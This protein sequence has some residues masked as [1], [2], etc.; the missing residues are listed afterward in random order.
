MGALYNRLYTFC[1]YV[2]TTARYHV[3]NDG[4]YL[5]HSMLM[6]MVQKIHA[7]KGLKTS[8]PTNQQALSYF[9]TRVLADKI[10]Y[11]MVYNK[12]M[13]RVLGDNHQSCDTTQHTWAFNS[14]LF[15]Y[16][17]LDMSK[18]IVKGTKNIKY[19][20]MV[21]YGD[22]SASWEICTT[23]SFSTRKYSGFASLPSSERKR[24]LIDSKQDWYEIDLKSA[25]FQSL[26][27]QTNDD[28]MYNLIASGD[29]YRGKKGTEEYKINKQKALSVIFASISRDKRVQHACDY[30]SLATYTNIPIT[31]AYG[32]CAYI[33]D[34]LARNVGTYGN[35]GNKRTW[36]DILQ[37]EQYIDNAMMTFAQQDKQGI[38]WITGAL[39]V[40]DAL[41]V[42]GADN[43]RRVADYL[44]SNRLIYTLDNIVA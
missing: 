11:R 24:L 17:D 26:A 38:H 12:G 16:I 7:I 15:N 10:G 3:A 14:N 22:K 43:A 30:A 5:S 1:S 34:L 44:S 37:I 39:R 41:Y 13:S 42:M 18:K 8:L 25:A 29:F 21:P 6:P 33:Q 9:C 36:A 20:Q 35:D 31:S 27:L 19:A 4:S 32:I 2:A 28:T 40:H 23:D